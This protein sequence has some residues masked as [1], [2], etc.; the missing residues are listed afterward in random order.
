MHIWVWFWTY[1]VLSLNL[2]IPS[3]FLDY[4]LITDK[5]VLLFLW[6]L[7]FSKLLW[8]LFQQTSVKHIKQAGDACWFS[9]YQFPWQNLLSSS[10][11]LCVY[12]DPVGVSQNTNQEAQSVYFKDSTALDLFNLILWFFPL[13][14]TI[15]I[16]YTHISF[17]HAQM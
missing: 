7:C 9:L 16:I 8:L 10:S 4:F 5:S 17:L 1:S 14:Q 2:L 15:A 12:L 3:P 6:T 11:T 13:S